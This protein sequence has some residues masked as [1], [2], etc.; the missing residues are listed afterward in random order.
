M[1]GAIFFQT[2]LFDLNNI[3][4]DNSCNGNTTFYMCKKQSEC[5]LENMFYLKNLLISQKKNRKKIKKTNS[6]GHQWTNSN[7]DLF[8]SLSMLT[9]ESDGQTENGAVTPAF[10]CQKAATGQHWWTDRQ[11]RIYSTV[12]AYLCGQYSKADL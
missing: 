9:H 10:V 11:Q 4:P 1:L 12:L 8:S 3:Y 2:W 7:E 5:K 6:I